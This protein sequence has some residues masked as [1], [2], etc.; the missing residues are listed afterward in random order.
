MLPL[1]AVA[2]PCFATEFTPGFDLC[3]APQPPS[4]V[5]APNKRLKREACEEAMQAYVER[6]F[7]FRECI[8]AETEREVR[9]A[10][11]VLDYWKCRTTKK[12]CKR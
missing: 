6:V 3:V 11:D 7:H 10:N 2:T 9:R 1:C 4:C 8:E 12:D 5:D